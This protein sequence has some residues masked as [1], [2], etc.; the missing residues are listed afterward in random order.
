VRRIFI[1]PHS[2]SRY[3]DRELAVPG[4]QSDQLGSLGAQRKQEEVVKKHLL[5]PVMSIAL[6]SNSYASSL[7][8]CGDAGVTRTIQDLMKQSAHKQIDDMDDLQLKLFVTGLMQQLVMSALANAS[9]SGGIKEEARDC[10]PKQQGQGLTVTIPT[11]STPEEKAEACRR[12]PNGY[13]CLPECPE[14]QATLH[15]T[16][17][18]PEQKEMTPAEMRQR[19]SAAID[20]AKYSFS[21]ARVDGEFSNKKFCSINLNVSGMSWFGQQNSTNY[22][23]EYTI[24]LTEDGKYWIEIIK[25]TQSK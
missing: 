19:F 5:A 23:E 16:P 14:G 2:N 18:K 3:L 22:V 21:A 11:K 1:S 9:A 12:N 6:V 25:E 13:G 17:T 24:Q 4:S 20:S 7:P 10:N 8:N 15:P